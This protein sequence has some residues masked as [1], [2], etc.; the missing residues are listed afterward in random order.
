MAA[1]PQFNSLTSRRGSDRDERG[2]QD[3]TEAHGQGAWRLKQ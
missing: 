1:G 2:V 3:S